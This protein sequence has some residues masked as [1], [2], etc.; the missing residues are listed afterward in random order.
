MSQ[1]TAEHTTTLCWWAL[2]HA[3]RRRLALLGVFATMLLKV[4][5]ELLKPLPMLVL[6]DH[7][8]MARPMSAAKTELSFFKLLDFIF[9]TIACFLSPSSYSCS[10]HA[11][12]PS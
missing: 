8:L 7:I 3:L 6:V 11:I 5:L 4:G 12:A 2:R 9:V 1:K 10:C